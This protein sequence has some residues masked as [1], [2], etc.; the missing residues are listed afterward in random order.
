[1]LS[2]H[3]LLN[4]LQ[5]RFNDTARVHFRFPFVI[6]EIRDRAFVNVPEGERERK[7]AECIGV[8][9]D[10]LRVET[11]RLF[12]RFDLGPQNE[13]RSPVAD[14]GDFWLRSLVEEQRVQHDG[15]APE[16][17]VRAIHFY[18]YKGGQARS[19]VLA[20]LSRVL[21]TSG[22]K[23]LVIDAAAA[24]PARRSAATVQDL[25]RQDLAAR[26]TSAILA[27]SNPW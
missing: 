13:A 9:Y 22:W 2:G 21:A 1:M 7:L 8:D 24:A 17:S 20:F 27:P 26:L 14:T 16:Q 19:S 10:T 15:V 5:Q 23:I 4:I 18:G 25:R 3:D 11:D 12:I 6:V